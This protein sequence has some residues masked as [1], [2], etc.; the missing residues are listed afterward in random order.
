M[1]NFKNLIQN[2]NNERKPSSNKAFITF[3]S[4][5]LILISSFYI[6]FTFLPPRGPNPP[7]D[8]ILTWGMAGSPPYLDP[9]D[10]MDSQANAIIRQCTEGLWGYNYSDPEFP[11]IRVLAENEEWISPTHLRVTLRPSVFFHD[12]TPFIADAAIWNLERLEYMCNHTGYLNPHIQRVTRT[13]SLYE[14][15]DGTPIIDHFTKISLLE[16]DIFLNSPFSDLL[17]IYAYVCGNMLSPTAHAAQ[18]HRFITLQENLVG[19]GP[20]IFDEYNANTDVIFSKNKYYEGPP[21]WSEPVYFDKLIFSI[22]DDDTSRNFAMLAGDIDWLQTV[23]PDFYDDFQSSPY[24]TFHESEIPGFEFSHIV[25]NHNKINTTWRKAISYAINY[26]YI[27]SDYQNN[28]VL[29]AYGPISPAFGAYYKKDLD[30]IAPYM[31]YSIA[32]QTIL[33]GLGS[34]AR[35][36]GLTATEYR[37]DPIND[38]DWNNAGLLTINYSGLAEDVFYFDMYLKLQLWL[39]RI[40]LNVTNGLTS[41]NYY[42][43]L[44]HDFTKNEI[45]LIWAEWVPEYLSPMNQIQPLM[46][47]I[48]FLNFGQINDLQMEAWFVQ[49]SLTTDFNERVELCHNISEYIV[50]VLYPHA[51]VYHPKVISIHAADLYNCPYNA[52]GNF[53]AYP[54]KRNESWT[55]KKI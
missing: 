38:A 40:G 55:P 4:I 24:I 31:N 26:T 53:W 8:K 15:P 17:D 2:Q 46:S 19:T 18:T 36:A 1:M 54:V 52:L 27:I 39:T 9:I 13:A 45:E 44:L 28:T 29:R 10:S 23:D 14:F 20:Y 12:M 35:I 48:S 3:L 32:R 50:T 5:G 30:V 42:F 47:N 49:W 16:F 41:L 25:M 33:D 51:Y 22:I 43:K 7:Q 34:D 37:E 6:I 21:G 11:L